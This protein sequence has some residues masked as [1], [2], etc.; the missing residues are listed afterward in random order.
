MEAQRTCLA[1]EA[2][3]HLVRQ[4]LLLPHVSRSRSLE[5]SP[6]AAP[7]PTPVRLHERR[8][9]RPC[10]SWAVV[11]QRTAAWGRRRKLTAWFWDGARNRRDRGWSVCTPAFMCAT[12]RR[13]NVRAPRRQS[14]GVARA[15]NTGNG[16]GPR[17]R[18]PDPIPHGIGGRRCASEG[19]RSMGT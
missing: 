3:R 8:A 2:H 5:S 13:C 1:F 12:D 14:A 9:C 10:A 17:G 6:G 7:W 4:C 16:V 11:S 15:R 19:I 18:L